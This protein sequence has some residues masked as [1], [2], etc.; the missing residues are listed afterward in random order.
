MSKHSVLYYPHWKQAPWTLWPPSDLQVDISLSYLPFQ[1]AAALFAGQELWAQPWGLGPGTLLHQALVVPQPAPGLEK[2]SLCAH[3][4][5]SNTRVSWVHRLLNIP[6][7]LPIPP[8]STCCVKGCNLGSQYAVQQ[9][10]LVN[11]W[12]VSNGLTSI[13]ELC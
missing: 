12:G 1:D 2:N 6:K 5:S 10:T 4:L 13:T 7:I 8:T 11:L 3:V 9:L